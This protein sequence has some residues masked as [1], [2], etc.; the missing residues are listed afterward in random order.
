[1][2]LSRP[3]P[4]DNIHTREIRCRGYLRKDGLWDIDGFL[5]DTKSYSFDNHDRQGIA[6]GEPIHSM[7]VRLTVDDELVVRAAEAATEAGPFGICADIAPVFASLVG[8]KIGS[9]WRKAVLGRMGGVC[10]CTHLT[11]LLLGPV[12]ATA[13]QTVAAARS[14]RAQSRRGGGKPP[15]LDTCHALAASSPVVQREWPEHYQGGNHPAPP[16]NRG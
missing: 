15:L 16:R 14:R 1:M 12:T 5:E 3:V 9:G 10:G 11:E 13:L 2:P 8:L 7:G 4:R 6:S